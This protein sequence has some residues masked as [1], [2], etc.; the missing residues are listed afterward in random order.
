LDESFVDSE[1]V[2]WVFKH[3]PLDIHP[4][5]VAAGVAAECAADQQKFWEM[6]DLLFAHVE[7]WSINDS[8]PVF[9]GYA[10]ELA[11]DVDQFNACLVAGDA[12]ARVQSDTSDGAPF[13]QGTPTFIVL[14]NGEGRIIPGA[15]PADS[16]ATA[17][18][19]VLDQAAQ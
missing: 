15:L 6:H 17:L 14:F 3:F 7:Q 13:V 19:E 12:L 16:F 10:S 11:L 5:A 4:Q 8:A 18:Q 2:Q 1:Q 9:A